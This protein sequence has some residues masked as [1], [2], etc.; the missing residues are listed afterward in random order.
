MLPAKQAEVDD[1]AARCLA[2]ALVR[3][4]PGARELS[5]ALVAGGVRL[6]LLNW[7]KPIFGP[8]GEVSQ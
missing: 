3:G 1:L 5:D 4:Y 2:A 7:P 6:P 8:R